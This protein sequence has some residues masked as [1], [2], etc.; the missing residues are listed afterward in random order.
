MI[1]KDKTCRGNRAVIHFGQDGGND[2]NGT[3]H[4]V[5]NTI[6]TPYISPVVQ[7]SAQRGGARIYN[8]IIC[9]GGAG[10][11]N[12]VIYQ[13]IQK[14][15]APPPVFVARN[16]LSYGFPGSAAQKGEVPPFNDPE[17]G[18]YTIKGGREAFTGPLMKLPGELLAIIEKSR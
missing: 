2:H 4:L 9:D 3:L 10:Q 11:S 12:Q 17:K 7:L 8:N 18:D 13:H 15:T 14:L 16:W 1:V 5:G 6:V